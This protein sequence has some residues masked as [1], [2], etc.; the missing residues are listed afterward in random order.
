MTTAIGGLRNVHRWGVATREQL[1]AAGI[2]GP[3]ISRRVERGEWRR[4][5]EAVYFIWDGKASLNARA[6]GALLAAGDEAAI[7]HRTAAEIDRMLDPEKT[8]GPI[9]ITLP[10]RSQQQLDDVQIHRAID[11]T[12]SQLTK[13]QILRRT[14]PVRTITDLAATSDEATLQRA[15]NEASFLG[16]VDLEELAAAAHSVR[17]GKRKLERALNDAARTRNPLEDRFYRILRQAKLP[18]PLANFRLGPYVPDFWWPDHNLIAETDG[19]AG[20]GHS[21]AR[22]KDRRRDAYF[23]GRQIHTHRIPKRQLE[24]EPFHM[25]AEIAAAIAV[26]ATARR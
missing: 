18:P 1:T 26:R 16:I 15:L 9:H 13:G 12:P 17:R 14:K 23:M 6:Y 5:H 4:M 10:R 20:H 11:L 22:L 19:W 24:R 3:T 7:S 2:S 25:V 8:P 21:F